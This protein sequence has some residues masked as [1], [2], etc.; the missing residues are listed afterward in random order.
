MIQSNPFS[1]VKRFIGEKRKKI[2][3][4]LL[5]ECK[6]ARL[7]SCGLDELNPKD[8]ETFSPDTLTEAEKQGFSPCPVC[9]WTKHGPLD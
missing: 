6:T 1:G 3:H 7:R 4:D 2:V 8:V 9:L 5:F